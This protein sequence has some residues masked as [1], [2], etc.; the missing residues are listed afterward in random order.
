MD[1]DL[2]GSTCIV[3]GSG[4]IGTRLAQRFHA[5]GKTCRIVDI[6]EPQ[7]ANHRAHYR[8]VDIRDSQALATAAVGCGAIINLAAAHRDDVRPISLY[9]Q[10][11][12]DGAENVCKAAD[13]NGIDTIIFTSS[14][15]VYGMARENADEGTPHLPFNEYGRTKS[16][17][18]KVYIRWQQRNPA[19]RRVVIV[20]PSVVFGPG[21]RGNVYNLLSQIANGRFVMVGDGL[22]RKSM[23]Y[24]Q[25]VAAFIAHV[26]HGPAGLYTYNYVDKP[27]LSMNEL[28][29][30]VRRSMGKDPE[31]G[32]RIP[33]WMGVALGISCDALARASRRTLPISKVRVAKFCSSTVFSVDR[34]RKE[35]GFVPPVPVQVA[36]Q[37]TIAADFI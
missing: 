10:V 20:R 26:L 23:A 9:R 16:D 34:A 7:T 12:V 32:V 22:N 6:V 36:L 37:D 14:V 1:R 4:F 31:I 28:I 3:G 18:E 25:N 8:N 29:G 33:Y 30:F 24:V 19:G 11:N 13:A 17:A 21:N 2:G 5:E 27:D 15:A 35:T